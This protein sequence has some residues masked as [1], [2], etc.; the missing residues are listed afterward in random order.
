MNKILKKI[1]QFCGLI[2]IVLACFN[3]STSF[4]MS[5]VEQ[6]KI[7]T[8]IKTV[9]DFLR[10]DEYAKALSQLETLLQEQPDFQAGWVI[11]GDILNMLAGRIGNSGL[12]ELTPSEQKNINAYRDEVVKRMSAL[13]REIPKNLVPSLILKLPEQEPYYLLADLTHS[14]LY[15]MS[16]RDP[17]TKSK[18]VLDLYMSQ[19]FNGAEK[20]REGD[21]RT[22]IGIYQINH[23]IPREKLQEFY[24]EGAFPLNYPNAWDRRMG[25]TGSG[26][27]IHGVPKTLFSRPP[28]ASNGCV[29]VSNQDV[30][31]L[32]KLISEEE[33]TQKI[34]MLITDEVEWVSPE[35]LLQQGQSLE[36][37]LE[38]WRSDWSSLD[39]VKYLSH[40]AAD[41]SSGDGM[42][43]EAWR[44]YKTKVN[45][46]KKNI[47]VTIKQVALFR[48]PKTTNLYLVRFLQQ[49]QSNNL[50]EN[51]MKEQYWRKKENGWEIVYEGKVK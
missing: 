18:V 43:L 35:I 6:K 29:V 30:W 37:A 16:N 11:Q 36:K 41:F 15:V 3:T 48:Y 7:D 10:R 47:N 28:L 38:S 31:K 42:N 5:E 9:I 4:A 34:T 40:Y 27:W 26:I 13:H 49:Y 32:K 1:T 45:A 50:S 24:G 14:R 44:A 46:T 25:K 39:T 2:S 20:I 23:F 21:N 17:S 8:S 19:G 22:P 51:T 33:H 12:S